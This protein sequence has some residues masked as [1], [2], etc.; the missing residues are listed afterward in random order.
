MPVATGEWERLRGLQKNVPWAQRADQIYRTIPGLKDFDWQR[1]FRE[2]T[3]LFA[4]IYRGILGL[5]GARTH[6]WGPRPLPSVGDAQ[7]RIR[8][9]QGEDYT[10]LPFPAALRQLAGRM[11][12]FKI[13]KL[14]GIHRS[15]IH[16]LLVGE[17]Q[18]DPYTLVTVARAFNKQPGYFLEYRVMV[19]FNALWERMRD[20]A[21]ES[22]I[23]IFRK[24]LAK[25]AS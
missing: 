25:E 16:R 4:D 11:G 20:Y 13:A 17:L 5:E 10:L 6:T 24:I 18:A 14:T 23:S 12:E 7:D 8:Q 22:S 19:I 15:T 2:D 21:P 1:A 9:W 3:Q